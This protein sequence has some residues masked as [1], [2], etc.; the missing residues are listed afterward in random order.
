MP[1]PPL[2]FHMPKFPSSAPR[3]LSV[4]AIL[5]F[6]SAS[7]FARTFETWAPGVINPA[8]GTV[9]LD[10]EFLRS[11]AEMSSDWRFILR[12]AGNGPRAGNTVLGIVVCPPGDGRGFLGLAK[13]PAGA[14]QAGAPT[15]RFAAGEVRRVALVWGEGSCDLWLDGRRLAGRRLVGELDALPPRFT[16]GQDGYFSIRAA[17]VSSVRRADDALAE[18]RP[19]AK[20]TETTWFASAD[21]GEIRGETRWQRTE[22]VA[23]L[24]PDRGA[25]DFATPVGTAL[26]VPLRTLNFTSHD[27]MFTVETEVADR[28]GRPVARSRTSVAAPAGSRHGEASFALPVIDQPGYHEAAVTIISASGRAAVHRL[29]FVVRLAED[30]PAGRLSNY[31]GH[32]H[33]L[34]AKPDAFARL[35]I[36][37]HRSWAGT[38]SFL[39]HAV[40]PAP[41]DF[42]WAEA[43]LALDIAEKH[44][45][46]TLGLLGNPPAWASTWSPEE[47]VRVRE[48][49]ARVAKAYTSHPDR[50]QPRD[51]EEWKRYVRAV[52]TRYRGRVSHWEIGNEMD[53]HPPFMHASFSGTTED[54]AE[55]LAAAAAIIREVD[56]AA[57]VLTTGFSLTRGVTD[58]DM[59]A[60]LMRLGAAGSFDI[61]AVHAYA[62]RAT[63]A[64]TIAAVRAAKPGVRLWQTERQYMGETRDDYQT[65]HSLFWCLEKGFDRYFLHEAD[66]DKNHGYLNPTPYYAVTS[67]VARQLRAADELTGPVP[68]SPASL[69]SW[70]LS[71][72]DGRHLQVFAAD[73][74]RFTLT[75]DNLPVGASV[76]AVDLYGELLHRG[77]LP[78]KTLVVE[79][80]VYVVSPV[81]LRVARAVRDNDN[82]VANSGFEV[83]EGDVIMDEEAARPASWLI[84][85]KDAPAGTLAFTAGRTGR[86][87]LEIDGGT[88]GVSRPHIV[89]RVQLDEAGP[90]RLG[91]WVRAA[92]GRDVAA[93]FYLQVGDGRW[94]SAR[95]AHLVPG[96]GE[97]RWLTYDAQ[98]P[99]GGARAYVL[100]GVEAGSGR[101][102]IDDVE[103]KPLV[104]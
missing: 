53:F 24:F 35:G 66:L 98:V 49:S 47:Q 101:L 51:I 20:D 88:P 1:T 59:P 90:W 54:Y 22:H 38:R 94:P 82:V 44:G 40:E 48:R 9:E 103:L 73:N 61:L 102:A 12:A 85:P 75:F 86:F 58:V 29:G 63:L 14:A 104:P 56:P 33:P 57:R 80:L 52:V 92:Q 83:R 32:H 84:R 50:Y 39:W 4:M 67:E 69:S 18:R 76:E 2:P 74:G 36:A 37:W 72:A 27:S 10:V 17:R 11:S 7:A 28:R 3:A 62:D 64:D 26:V 41:G 81:P 55:M 23:D 68:G 43:D 42:Q 71:R 30:A 70:R 5:V 13:S 45:I 95:D 25:V 31:L 93:R 6:G 96:D 77:P 21:G 100:I 91:A 89:Q 99:E 8:V 34:T 19:L 65:I 60:E 16:V 79:G 97:W 78:D 87:S 15:P 46:R